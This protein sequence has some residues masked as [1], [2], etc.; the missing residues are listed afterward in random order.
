MLTPR[1]V[2]E[3]LAKYGAQDYRRWQ[4]YRW[5]IYDF[6]RY[7]GAG[8]ATSPLSLFSVPQGGADPNAAAGTSGSP[9]TLEQTNMNQS[10]Q[11]GTQPFAIC[12]LR[13]YARILP[14][15]RQPANISDDTD[16]LWTVISNMMSKFLELLR[17]GLLVMMLNNKEYFTQAAP[18]LNFP[19]G[20][21]VRIQEHGA[22]YT[23]G[24]TDFSIWVQ[25]SPRH[26]DIFD[27]DPPLVIG[28]GETFTV[29]ISYP[30]GTG[31]SFTTLV[32][33]TTPFLD[34]GVIFDGYTIRPG[35]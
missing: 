21:G 32:S 10:G 12:E 31:P 1:L 19:P 33:S 14:K 35:S 23:S 15:N 26:E 17:R 2:S 25:Q 16:L 34:V 8:G 11:V 22:V 24:F 3:V 13:T 28:I 7:P 18:F 9:K 29:Q 6:V 5:Q 20:F 4:N 30:D 27:V